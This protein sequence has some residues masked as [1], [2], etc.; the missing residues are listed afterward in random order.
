MRNKVIRTLWSKL[1]IRSI[2]KNQPYEI[3]LLFIVIIWI[4]GISL[5]SKNFLTIDNLLII[6]RRMSENCIVAIGMTFVIITGGI[7]LSVGSVMA[8][9]VSIGGMLFLN[10]FSIW[11]AFAVGICLSIGFGFING[12]LI[13][14]IKLQP[15]I[16][17]LATMIIVRSISYGITL[18]KAVGGFPKIFNFIG[19]GYVMG[20]PFPFLLMILLVILSSFILHRTRLGRYIYA[21]GGNEKTAFALGINVS[22]IKL[23]VYLFSS[24]MA[25]CAGIIYASRVGAANPAVGEAASLDAITA[26][27]IGGASIAGG[28]GRIFGTIVGVF[29]VTSLINGLHLIGIG[30]YWQIIFVG[31][32]LLFAVSLEGKRRKIKTVVV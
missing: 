6:A 1:R 10:G 15:I 16:V 23:F 32:A 25:S 11:T 31:G 14:K 8:L 27:L 9:T 2:V 26:V 5:L 22:E 13:V 7:D 18:G 3:F 4:I 29:L 28:K 20:L 19:Q 12:L 24:I 17:T 21:V 30:A